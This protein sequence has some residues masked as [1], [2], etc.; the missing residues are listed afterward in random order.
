MP[1]QTC[2]PGAGL[3]HR[4]TAGESRGTPKRRYDDHLGS[5]VQAASR[6]HERTQIRGF[7]RTSLESRPECRFV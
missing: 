1:A 3:E 5:G 6:V 2:A 7:E 4:L